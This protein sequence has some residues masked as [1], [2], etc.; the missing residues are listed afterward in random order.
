[1][2]KEPACNA[3]DA[4]NMGSIP[5]SERCPGAGH[6]KPL[7][8]SCLENSMDRRAW[9]AIVYRLE[10]IDHNGSDSARM[11]YNAVLVSGI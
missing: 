2:G 4:G 1:M 9:W 5:G 6:S 3:G 8:F 10:K 11:I 7:Q